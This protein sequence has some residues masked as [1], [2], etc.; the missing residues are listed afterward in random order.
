M[1][2]ELLLMT[3]TLIAIGITVGFGV[4]LFIESWKNTME[5]D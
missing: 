5:D 3:T 1:V 4:Y 2:L